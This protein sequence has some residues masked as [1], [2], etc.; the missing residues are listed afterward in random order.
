MQFEEIIAYLKRLDSPEGLPAAAA[1]EALVFKEP[2]SEILLVSPAQH[3]QSFACGECVCVSSSS[4]VMKKTLKELCDKAE[5]M[6]D[7]MPGLSQCSSSRHN[8]GWVM[9]VEGESRVPVVGQLLV[10]HAAKT[11][12]LPQG[13]LGRAVQQGD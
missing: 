9:L 6:N 2:N 13:L 12:T 11:F 8:V 1:E 4:M 10:A 7:S 3:S 5:A